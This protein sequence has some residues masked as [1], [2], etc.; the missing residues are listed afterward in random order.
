MAAAKVTAVAVAAAVAAA[1]AVRA[2]VVK[3]EGA[4]ASPRRAQTWTTRSPSDAKAENDRA[5][6]ESSRPFFMPIFQRV[7]HQKSVAISFSDVYV[8]GN[9]EMK[10]RDRVISCRSIS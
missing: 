10:R 9:L 8:R 2:A 5:A 1:A 7:S 6:D 3:A 4:A